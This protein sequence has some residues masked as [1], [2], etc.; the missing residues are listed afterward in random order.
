MERLR[1]L[2][3]AA[4]MTMRQVGELIGVAESTV[5]LYERG[6]RRPK[7]AMLLKL[8]DQ[9]GVS[10]DYLLGREGD[11]RM[12]RLLHAA[13]ATPVKS[14]GVLLPVYGSIRAG[15]PGLA[16]EEILAW[17]PTEIDPA[18]RDNYYY[19]Q[20]KGDSM[21]GA[22]IF[23]GSKVLV[24][25]QRFAESGQIAACMLEGEETTLK[26]FRRTGNLVALM[27]ENSKYQPILLSVED[28]DSGRA[29]ILGV[30]VTVVT[31]LS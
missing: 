9:F 11:A 1:E 28:F 27:P 26:R 6:Q 10:V 19:L 12:A 15:L 14:G 25:K 17:Y 22:G 21:E 23:D 29:F 5:S 30:A 31:Q 13:G 7:P 20:V 18:E 16:D 8:A 4:G 2:R 24:R 3:R